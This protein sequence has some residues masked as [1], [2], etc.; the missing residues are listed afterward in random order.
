MRRLGW[1]AT[2]TANKD[3]LLMID[4]KCAAAIGYI[5]SALHAARL[6]EEAQTETFLYHGGW[7]SLPGCLPDAL[8]SLKSASFES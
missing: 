5:F 8:C 3:M 2:C 1:H 6:A 7:L 4:A